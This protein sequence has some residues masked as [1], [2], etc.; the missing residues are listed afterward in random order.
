MK[1]K[2]IFLFIFFI[3]IT[4]FSQYNFEASEKYPFGRY[5]PKAPK[6]LQDY[7]GLIGECKC[8]S[9]SR[10]PD[11]TWAKPVKMNWLWKYIMNGTGVQDMTLK[12]DGSHGGSIRQYNADSLSWYVHYYTAKVASPKLRAWSGN[13]NK[14]GDIVLYSNQKAPNGTEGFSRLTFYDI[15]SKGYKWKGE[16]VDKT[17]TIVYPF[18][19]ISCIKQK[20]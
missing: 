1:L 16:W 14:E 11:G 18:W 2:L 15:D 6:E 9:E 7:Q 20:K 12:E 13:K 3:S 4:T 5:N 10:K 19:K 8:K 17:E